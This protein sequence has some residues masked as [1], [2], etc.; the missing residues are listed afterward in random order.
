M[1]RWQWVIFCVILLIIVLFNVPGCPTQ[2]EQ[3]AVEGGRLTASSWCAGVPPPAASGRSGRRSGTDR[4]SRLP[5]PSPHCNTH[6]RESATAGAA[7]S[8][9]P[10]SESD[11]QTQPSSRSAVTWCDVMQDSASL[12]NVML[13]CVTHHRD[14]VCVG[15]RHRI[16]SLAGLPGAHR[17]FERWIFLFP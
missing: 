8:S 3:T 11:P 15:L 9:R 13:T 1:T 14:S 2:W 16:T 17:G 6:K 12:V 7:W 5:T 10:S 4:G